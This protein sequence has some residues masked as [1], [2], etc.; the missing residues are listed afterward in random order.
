MKTN[1]ISPEGS[2]FLKKSPRAKTGTGVSYIPICTKIHHGINPNSIMRAGR[3]SNRYLVKR[4]IWHPQK[5][6]FR[7]SSFNTNGSNGY[8]LPFYTIR[9][10]FCPLQEPFRPEFTFTEVKFG[11]KMNLFGFKHFCTIL[12]TKKLDFLVHVTIK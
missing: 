9:I 4:A 12:R 5:W 2:V 7:Q 3:A 1:H 8:G 11:Q 10:C 6:T